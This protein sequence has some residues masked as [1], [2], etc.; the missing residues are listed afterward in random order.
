VRKTINFIGTGKG[1]LLFILCLLLVWLSGYYYIN[2]SV[3][4]DWERYI[5]QRLFSRVT[6]VGA[7]SIMLVAYIPV[8][9]LF[10]QNTQKTATDLSLFRILFFGFFAVG[11]ILNPNSVSDQVMPFVGL[12]ESAQVPIP[13]VGWFQQWIPI[14]EGIVKVVLPIF[15]L[16]IFTSLIGIKSRW[17]ILVFTLTL[18]YLFAIPNFFGKVNHNH[19]LIWFPAILAFSPCS[20]RFS[21][22]AYFNSRKGLIT[23]RSSQAYTQPFYTSGH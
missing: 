12:P 5:Y 3:S 22:D 1:T 9:R 16:S 21:L 4:D 10:I 17:S 14:N 18:L 13:F 23:R 20:D 6:L 11:F 8:V 2:A 19:H 15:Y 7:L